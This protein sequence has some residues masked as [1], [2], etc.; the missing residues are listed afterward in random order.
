MAKKQAPKKKAVRKK[1]E[2]L[3]FKQIE[4]KEVNK[5][6][7]PKILTRELGELICGKIAEGSI[8]LRRICE[9]EGMPSYSSVFNWIG[10]K[11]NAWF[12]DLYTR[13]REMQADRI[14]D[15][16]ME[17][18]DDNRFDREAFVGGNH[19][20]R[21]KLRTDVRKWRAAKLHPKKYGDKLD[22][23]NDGEKFQGVQVYLPDNNRPVKPND[24]N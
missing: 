7:A 16:I 12:L 8:G 10:K 15:E 6:G 9:E 20:Q 18:A 5:G 19:I 14:A 2:K 11:E 3:P 24:G 4:Y 23:T 21:D 22:L 17:I 13:A 1:K